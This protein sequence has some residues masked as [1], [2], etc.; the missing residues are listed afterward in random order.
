MQ[1]ISLFKGG[2]FPLSLEERWFGGEGQANSF[3][4][5]RPCCKLFFMIK[6]DNIP[7]EVNQIIKTLKS[8]GSQA[9]LVGGSIRDQLLGLP[10]NEW[11]ITTSARPEEVPKLFAK[12]IPTGIDF[13]TV[14]VLLEGKAFEVTTF[15][16]DEKYVDGRHP[17]N[18]RFCQ[19]IHQDL[20][21]RDFTINALAYDPES[22]ELIDDFGGQNDLKAKIIRTVGSPIERFS[23]DGLRSVRACRFAA[24]LGFI[25]EA[26]TLA[27]INQTLATTAKVAPER[28]HDELAKLLSAK[29]PSIGLEYMRQTSL[30]KLILPELERCVGVT[31]PNE[32]HEYD[33]YWHNLKACDAAS[34][35][36]LVVRL[37][38]LFHDIE[39]PSCQVEETFYDH[40]QKGGETTANILRRLKFSKLEIEQVSNLVTQHMFNYTSDWNDSAVR[41][42][43]RRIGGVQNVAPLFALRRADTN[44]MKS[45]VGAEYLTKLQKRID[46]IIVEE[47][48]LRVTDLKV[49][50]NDIMKIL[51]LKPGPRVGEILRALLNQVLDNPELNEKNKLLELAKTIK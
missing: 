51:K 21:R 25:I 13:G 16:A 9:Y 37:A 12:V 41:R 17:D 33:V 15:R 40:D 36:N 34:A 5:S 24:K 27:A 45:K 48:A 26:K 19:D 11:D 14:T 18:V 29:E 6:L 35:D 20:S 8:H 23:E 38:A 46:K 30:L 43:I 3:T 44:A 10:V 31:Q 42:F 49:D 28:I 4:L 7:P 22:K 47:D 2:K 50:G 39:K 32:Y 1:K